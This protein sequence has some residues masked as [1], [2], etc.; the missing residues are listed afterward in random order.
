MEKLTTLKKKMSN[1]KTL[2]LVAVTLLAVVIIVP[3]VAHAGA[4]TGDAFWNIYDQV[5]RWLKGTLGQ[6]L[7]IAVFGVGLGLGLMRQ[8]MVACI[9]GLAFALVL[10]YGPDAIASIF[11]LALVM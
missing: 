11:T 4:G 9:A 1:K 5:A 6:A 3:I 7:A 8:S 10:F 2:A